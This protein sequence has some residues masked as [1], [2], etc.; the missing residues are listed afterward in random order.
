MSASG[1]EANK[2][3]YHVQKVEKW[4]YFRGFQ[5]DINE[6]VTQKRIGKHILV[7]CFLDKDMTTK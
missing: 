4:K 1:K 5:I 6:K 7:I 2:E 3:I